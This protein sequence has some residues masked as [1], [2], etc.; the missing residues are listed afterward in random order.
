MIPKEKQME[1]F[2]ISGKKIIERTETEKFYDDIQYKYLNLLNELYQKDCQR[3]EFLRG[4]LSVYSEILESKKNWY[5][6]PVNY[7][8]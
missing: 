4:A 7:F 1:K 5:K 3:V 6:E 8:H 2:T